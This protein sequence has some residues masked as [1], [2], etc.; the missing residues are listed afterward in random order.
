MPPLVERERF[1]ATGAEGHASRS[2]TARRSSKAST[3]RSTTDQIHAIMGPNGSGKSTLA[4]ALMG[5]PAYE[6][7]E[8]QVILTTART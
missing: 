1:G 4:Y 3:S 2:R 5:H 7:T 6:I 8:G